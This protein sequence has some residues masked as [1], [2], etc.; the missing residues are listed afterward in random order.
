MLLER[1]TGLATKIAEYQKLKG[2]ADNAEQF[3]TRANQFG[4]LSEKIARTRAALE[5]LA[6]AGIGVSFAP[7]DGVGYAAKAETLRA[8]LQDNPAAINAP[9]FDLKHKFIDRISGIAAAADKA[10]TDAWKAYVAKRA[11]LGANDVLSALAEVP[12]FRPTVTTIQRCRKDIAALG[13]SLPTDPKATVARMDVLVAEH[14]TAWATL[15]AENIPPT[16]I[17]F[18]RVAANEGALLTAYTDEVRAWLESRNLLNAFRIRL[19]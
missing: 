2:A 18:I 9:P 8:A 3:Q 4:A 11:D 10:M 17:S 5:A 13:N 19:R 1:A 15:S 7:T 6:D 12:Q 16:V 14:D